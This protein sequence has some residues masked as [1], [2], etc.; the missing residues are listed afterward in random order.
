M[1]RYKLIESNVRDL[2]QDLLERGFAVT[3]CKCA[4]SIGQETAPKDLPTAEGKKL[5]NMSTTESLF[6]ALTKSGTKLADL[7]AK[8]SEVEKEHADNRV[9]Y[10]KAKKEERAEEDKKLAEY[11][12]NLSGDPHPMNGKSK[13][14]AKGKASGEGSATPTQV[15]TVLQSITDLDVPKKT[16]IMEDTKLDAGTVKAAIDKLLDDEKIKRGPGKGAGLTY[17]VTKK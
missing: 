9:A 1:G 7:K 15:S 8:I 17:K 5:E 4:H 10:E 14:K 11:G 2:T 12:V 3:L 6:N 16:A 13:G